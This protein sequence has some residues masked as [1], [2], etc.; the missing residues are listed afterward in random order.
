[1]SSTGMDLMPTT[2][3]SRRR[4]AVRLAKAGWYASEIAGAL[5]VSLRTVERYKAQA[6]AEAAQ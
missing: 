6:R 3:A 2:V 5:G 4:R 1:M